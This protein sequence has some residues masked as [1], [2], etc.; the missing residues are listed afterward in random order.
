MLKVGIT[1]GIGSG[2]TTVCYIFECLNIPVYY[3]DDRG[4]WLMNNDPGV[5]EAITDLFGI[6]AYLNDGNLNRKYLAD[7]VFQNQALLN[8][9]N[10]IVHPAVAK[11]TRAWQ[12]QQIN[13][14][15]TLKEAAILFESGGHHH[16]DYVIVVDAPE[17]LRIDRVMHRDGISAEAVKARISK[18]M[19]TAKKRAMADFIIE[20]DGHRLLVPQVLAIHRQLIQ[21]ADKDSALSKPAL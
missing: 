4:K 3:A 19:P 8:Q 17:A 12:S 7:Q 9:L 2:K 1:G 14:P 5:K 10:A 15:Y 16:L 18:Q 11:D 6:H 21:L 13:V 20:N